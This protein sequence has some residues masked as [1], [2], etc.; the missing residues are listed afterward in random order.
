MKVAA[1]VFG[2]NAGIYRNSH[3]S[4]PEASEDWATVFPSLT[5]PFRSPAEL[6]AP[7]FRTNVKTLALCV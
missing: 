2:R 7:A 3:F 6:K 4:P 5:L 1:L